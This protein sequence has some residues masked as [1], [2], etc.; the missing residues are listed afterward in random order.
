M[1]CID[2]VKRAAAQTP[3]NAR[4]GAGTLVGQPREGRTELDETSRVICVVCAGKAM[5]NKGKMLATH[6]ASSG[7]ARRLKRFSTLVGN[8]PEMH[9]K[10]ALATSMSLDARVA[11]RIE[12]E[13]S[14]RR[15]Q[16]YLAARARRQKRA[17]ARK[18]RKDIKNE[19]KADKQLKLALGKAKFEE[20]KAEREAQKAKDAEKLAA[21][22]AADKYA[23]VI[24][25]LVTSDR[26]SVLF[27]HSQEAKVAA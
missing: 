20:I 14:H 8:K 15:E 12:R 16:K 17:E 2:A 24:L 25:S 19:Q 7:H 10:D 13:Q 26:P 18:L 5:R 21:Q 4:A 23:P 11:D 1:T 9:Q 27:L 22:G 3:E 6:V